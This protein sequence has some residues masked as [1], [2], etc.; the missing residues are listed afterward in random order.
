VSSVTSTTTVPVAAFTV[1]YVTTYTATG[2]AHRVPGNDVVFLGG[3]ETSVQPVCITG[4]EICFQFN[5][6]MAH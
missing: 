6:L 3:R 1:V 5:P 2:H 4:S